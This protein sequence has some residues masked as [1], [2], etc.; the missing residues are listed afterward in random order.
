MWPADVQ[1][2]GA[3]TLQSDM[4]RSVAVGLLALFALAVLPQSVAAHP[5][6]GHGGVGLPPVPSATFLV[7][8]SV[9]VGSLLGDHSGLL[10]RRLADGGLVV[11]I[12]ASLTGLAWFWI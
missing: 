4:K 7:G 6:H 11:G 2:K 10:E 1:Y 8:V 3:G 5:G 12:L 9:L